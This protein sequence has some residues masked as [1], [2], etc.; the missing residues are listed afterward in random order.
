MKRY[1]GTRS[2]NTRP[3][4]SSSGMP[5]NSRALPFQVVTVPSRSMPMMA[6]GMDSMREP[7]WSLRSRMCSASWVW[8]RRELAYRHMFWNRSFCWRVQPWSLWMRWTQNS[9]VPPRVVSMGKAM[10]ARHS[11]VLARSNS[12]SRA[13]CNS[14]SRSDP[15]WLSGTMTTGSLHSQAVGPPGCLAAFWRSCTKGPGGSAPTK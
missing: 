12:S 14:A 5:K 9:E 10:A 15:N 3:R 11:T 7:S 8:S 4:A 1:S 6:E 13:A 2:Q